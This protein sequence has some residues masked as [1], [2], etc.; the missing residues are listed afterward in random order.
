M[1]V[2]AFDAL[3]S[4]IREPSEPAGSVI[5]VPGD[6]SVGAGV[7][8]DRAMEFADFDKQSLPGGEALGFP[9]AAIGV[10]VGCYDDFHELGIWIEIIQD[11]SM[12]TVTDIEHSYQD[13]PS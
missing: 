9:V 1:P 4:S 10:A 8:D 11:Q 7:G 2:P 6:K 13:H 12:H 3:D 5:V